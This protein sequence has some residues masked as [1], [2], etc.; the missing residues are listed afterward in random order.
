MDL[1]KI[2][3]QL[4]ELLLEQIRVDAIAGYYDLPELRKL[5][6]A[7]GK[8]ILEEKWDNKRFLTIVQ[9]ALKLSKNVSLCKLM[10]E[11]ATAHIE[12][13]LKD[14]HFARMGIIDDFAFAIITNLVAKRRKQE[15]WCADR[16]EAL[17]T[18]LYVAELGA[19]LAE[20][21]KEQYEDYA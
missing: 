21:D 2:G 18:Q 20:N 14:D 6:N 12:E 15:K 19:E 3:S 17:R 1:P 7:K 8:L 13:L 10:A 4:A 16:V 5:A 11:I 9:E